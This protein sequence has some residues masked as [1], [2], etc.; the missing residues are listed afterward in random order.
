MVKMRRLVA[1][2]SLR[3]TIGG[4]RYEGWVYRQI[5]REWHAYY[6]GV[7]GSIPWG[8]SRVFD[9]LKS[10]VIITNTHPTTCSR[11]VWNEHDLEVIT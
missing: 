3:R 2:R 5:D 7:D 6:A 11:F 9:T 10:A 4:W 1:G 8:T